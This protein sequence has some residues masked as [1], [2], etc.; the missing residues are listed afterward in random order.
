MM[1]G[2]TTTGGA[3][4]GNGRSEGVDRRR[5]L[6]I[7]AAAGGAAAATAVA[8]GTWTKPVAHVGVLPAHAQVSAIPPV[9]SQL[10]IGPYVG[11]GVGGAF[12][13][14]ATFH[15]VDPLHGVTD[16][17]LITAT[18]GTPSAV[19]AVG[20]PACTDPVPAP[21]TSLAA[22]GAH[23]PYTPSAGSITFPF[24]M[25]CTPFDLCVT[26]EAGGRQSLPVCALSTPV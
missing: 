20:P 7:V 8:P 6:R 25:L 17:A 3:R 2:K 16:S 10:V 1:P 23:G 11:A 4:M 14:Q 19:R 5:F 18:L 15:F 24:Q 21:G 9:L 26:L 12:T 13:H 22:L